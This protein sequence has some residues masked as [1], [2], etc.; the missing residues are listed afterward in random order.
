M[1]CDW[2]KPIRTWTFPSTTIAGGRRSRRKRSRGERYEPDYDKNVQNIFT[3]HSLPRTRGVRKGYNQYYYEKPVKKVRN[4]YRQNGASLGKRRL[5]TSS[6]NEQKSDGWKNQ[7]VS[8][9]SKLKLVNVGLDLLIRFLKYLL[10][11]L[12]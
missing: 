11:Y 3:Y 1:F 9:N 8:I 10:D 12:T 4:Y 6:N 5:E 7:L 2:F